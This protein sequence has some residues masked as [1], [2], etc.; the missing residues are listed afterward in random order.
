MYYLPRYLNPV[1]WCILLFVSLL[2]LS[3]SAQA[4]ESKIFIFLP[5]ILAAKSSHH[6]PPGKGHDSITSWEGTATCLKCHGTQG[7]EVFSSLHYQW[8]GQTPYLT[9]GPAVQGKLDMG[10]NSYCIN[11]TGNWAGCSSCHAG[12]GLK[13]E[14]QQSQEQ[15]DNIDCLICHQSKY[16]R[17]KVDGRYVPD[18]DNMS[19][20]IVEAAR[21]VH[22]PT[23]A[24]C[25]QCHAKG[26]GGDNFKRGD[27]ALAH[28]STADK[29][30]DIHMATTGA[31]L[32]CQSCHKT[33]KHRIAGRGS[34]LR[35]TDLDVEM[36]CTTCHTSKEI[37][38]EHEEEIIDIH[39]SRIACQTCHIP[40]YARNAS[41]TDATEKTETHRNWLDPKLTSSGAIH[42]TPTLAGDLIPRYKWWN[43]TSTAYLLH[44]PAEIDQATNRIPTSR[45]VGAVNDDQ[46]RLFPFKYKTALQPLADSQN[47]LIALDTSVYFATGDSYTATISG[48][49]NMGLP[50]TTPFSW[51]ETDTYQLITHEIMP[52]SGAL[53]CSDC[54]ESKS[55]M[56]L[57]G[58]LGYALKG[59]KSSVC[60]QCHENEE[61]EDDKS[62]YRWIHDKHVDDKKY[63]CSWCHNFSRP[64][65]NLKK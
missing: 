32:N 52:A 27:M 18:T 56:D 14:K 13:P 20:S 35:A 10:V 11:I 28:I 58:K 37:I 50:S 7:Q 48:L 29:N 60:I 61:E 54:H 46:S 9:G 22:L 4:E 59:P 31:N 3:E 8:L 43:G 49:E 41:D 33:Q 53:K 34:D 16:K 17:K 51:V 19:V 26:G 45:P 6:P 12:L 36:N 25:L 24:T 42:P 47:T 2:I 1:N 65:R 62:G 5:A 21:T 40:L 44:D 15:L 64:E 57:Q 30:F 63:D 23:R 38:S 39:I 55:R